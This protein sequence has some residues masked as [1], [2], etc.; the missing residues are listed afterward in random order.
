MSNEQVVDYLRE[1]KEKFSKEALSEQLRQSGY[2]EADIVSGMAAVYDEGTSPGMASVARFAGFWIR[3]VAA[4]IDGIIM[5]VAGSI[6][7]VLLSMLMFAGIRPYDD[8]FFPFVI[9]SYVVQTGIVWAYNILMIHHKGATIGKMALGLKVVSADGG[10]A[11]LGKIVLRETIGKFVS[12]ITLCIGFMMVGWTKKK[13]GLHDMI[14]G[15][16]VVRSR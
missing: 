2:P 9:V 5:S 13:Q 3:V 7:G 8:T 10:R 11:A 16:V 6:A 1:N 15:T 4:L 14:A 12:G